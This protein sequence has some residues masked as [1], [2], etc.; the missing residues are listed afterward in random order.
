MIN[1]PNAKFCNFVCSN[2]YTFT[3]CPQQLKYAGFVPQMQQPLLPY[4]IHL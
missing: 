2:L 4:T 3:L 1:H